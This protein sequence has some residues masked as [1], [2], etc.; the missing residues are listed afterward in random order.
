MNKIT[1]AIPFYNTS[2][3]F[4]DCI[5]YAIDNEFVDEIVVNDDG[6]KEQEYSNLLNIVEQLNT[7]KIKVFKNET[8]QGAFRNKYETVSKCS[9]DWI[10][11]LD[12]DNYPFE[13]TYNILQ[14]IDIN[15]STKNICYSP[16]KLYCKKDEEVDYSTISDYN[17]F[18]YE[19]IGIEESKDALIKR[20]KWFDWFINTGNYFFNKDFYLESLQEPFKNYLKYKLYADTAAAF[21]F[22]L[23]NGGVFKIVPDLRHNHRLRSDSY[24]NQCGDE[25]MATVN[26]YSSM[27]LEL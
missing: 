17:T 14:N 10:Y 26:L 12:S 4:L 1:L 8:N 22:I 6:S 18:N 19:L 7:N 3:Y 23:K 16:A 5:G 15:Q 11:L 27:I 9:N 21:Y 25:S 2:K 20:K 24:W 13:T